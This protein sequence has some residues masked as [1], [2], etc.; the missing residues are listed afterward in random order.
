MTTFKGLATIATI[1]NNILEKDNNTIDIDI[2][3]YSQFDS[4]Y[5]ITIKKKGSHK[6]DDIIVKEFSISY[7]K[8]YTIL[9]DIEKGNINK[10]D[11]VQQ[12]E[13]LVDTI[14]S[15]RL[16]RL[17]DDKYEKISIIGTLLNE[18]ILE[19]KSTISPKE[20]YR[21]IR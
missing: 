18:Y 14:N 17:V 3:A 10:Y 5:A 21:K 20:V 12:K 16:Y 4:P 19:D 15:K 13:I 1:V 7:F 11:Y 8:A 6:D 9:K 2:G